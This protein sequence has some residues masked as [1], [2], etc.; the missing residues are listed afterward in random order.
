MRSW[1][2]L[3]ALV[4]G[5]CG[6][7]PSRASSTFEASDEGWTISGNGEA[8]KPVLEK[9]GGN[10]G[11]AICGQDAVEGDVW[12][13]RAPEK[14]LGDA[15]GSYGKRLTFD[16]RQDE[17]LYQL[18]GRDVIVQGGGLAVTIN[19]PLRPPKQWYPYSF[20]LSI[21]DA[22][23]RDDLSGHGPPAT[24][25]EL[26]T[27]LRDINSIQIRGEFYDGPLDRA[28]LDNVYFG[29]D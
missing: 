16:L 25:E 21:A 28:C 29:R 7:I 4:A 13:F 27:V 17:F 20:V 2:V 15:S 11:A 26:R 23:T 10:P 1:P 3:I 14:Y 5:A 24:E 12:Y 18:S 19:L 6:G 9:E 8:T 22:W